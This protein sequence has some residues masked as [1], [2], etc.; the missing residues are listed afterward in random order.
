[1]DTL[2]SITMC[3]TNKRC[4]LCAIPA[5]RRLINTSHICSKTQSS[6]QYAAINSYDPVTGVPIISPNIA[7]ASAPRKHIS[8]VS[9]LSSLST[10][11][12]VLYSISNI[13]DVVHFGKPDTIT[14]GDLIKATD[15]MRTQVYGSTIAVEFRD[16]QPHRLHMG[17]GDIILDID[18]SVISLI[19]TML[20]DS[21]TVSWQWTS[22]SA[23]A[24]NIFQPNYNA[25][26]VCYN[27]CSITRR[28]R[29]SGNSHQVTGIP[30]HS[31]P[32]SGDT[33][34]LNI[35][36]PQL[37]ATD[38][39]MGNRGSLVKYIASEFLDCVM[40]DGRCFS[41][42]RLHGIHSTIRNNARRDQARIQR[43]C[44]SDRFSECLTVKQ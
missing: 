36:V 4:S 30:L 9:H 11:I 41:C 40:K 15:A 26:W 27:G 38:S 18:Q 29:L 16:G 22:A 12:S 7:F 24:A 33:I 34:T 17:G 39:T 6:W 42:N 37:D 19:S 32:D 5:L 28:F 13:A 44:L 10:L 14:Y 21:E 8:C 3:D 2:N 23:W 35:G 1:V 20:S 43:V 31:N 25:L